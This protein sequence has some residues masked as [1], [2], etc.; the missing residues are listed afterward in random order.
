[1]GDDDVQRNGSRLHSRPSTRPPPRC[2]AA[3]SVAP[4]RAVLRARV[5]PS[6][7]ALDTAADW[8]GDLRALLRADRRDRGLLARAR[9][10]REGRGE[11][12]SSAAGRDH[13]RCACCRSSSAACCGRSRG[14]GPTRGP[15]ATRSP[16]APTS[17]RTTSSR[18]ARRRARASCWTTSSPTCATSST[19]WRRA[20]RCRRSC[21]SCVAS[22]TRCSG[23]ATDA[24]PPRAERKA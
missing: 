15:S 10:A 21:G 7:E 18:R 9:A 16:T 14:C 23:S 20:A 24:A 19:R 1:M 12:P 11:A 3:A 8:L 22:S 4:R 2:A 5:I 13:R 6:G 17:T